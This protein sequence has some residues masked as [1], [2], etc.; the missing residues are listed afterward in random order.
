MDNPQ[1]VL[2]RGAAGIGKSTIALEQ[3]KR[4]R[5]QNPSAVVW[6]LTPTVDLAR[7]LE[8]K[9]GP[10]ASVVRGRTHEDD[11]E[12]PLCAK[13]ALVHAAAGR[14]PNVAEAFCF[15]H[16]TDGRAYR[17]EHRFDCRYYAQFEVLGQVI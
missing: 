12:G 3:I 5:K 15:R 13:A 6:Y 11:T 17:C 7:E 1:P 8:K 10:G 2:M 9:Y 14:V 16:D 4:W